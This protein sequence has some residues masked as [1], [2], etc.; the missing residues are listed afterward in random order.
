[1]VARFVVRA[2]QGQGIVATSRHREQRSPPGLPRRQEQ[3]FGIEAA[4]DL[5][6]RTVAPHHQFLV[7]HSIGIG[8]NGEEGQPRQHAAV[9]HS[10][11]R[12]Q[13]VVSRRNGQD[14]AETMLPIDPLIIFLQLRQ[15]VLQAAHGEVGIVF[16][17]L[18]A[19][20][21]HVGET[22]VALGGRSGGI[23][24]GQGLTGSGMYLVPLSVLVGVFHTSVHGVDARRH[25]GTAGYGHKQ[26][27]TRA[28]ISATQAVRCFGRK[29]QVQGIPHTIDRHV[30]GNPARNFR[31][32]L[33][34]RTELALR[35]SI[36]QIAA[37]GR[38]VLGRDARTEHVGQLVGIV[39][40]EAGVQQ[41]VVGHGHFEVA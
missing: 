31:G 39:T 25:A 37:P 32:S 12:G 38:E 1:M 17:V 21:R 5:H 34:E 15:S 3:V 35:E 14:L 23:T 36:L 26:Q 40:L 22:Q 7:L 28:G 33:A 16:W 8:R 29:P 4:D 11:A 19:V 27:S 24:L 10:C 41:V 9:C 2:Q 30:L 20:A 6:A 18:H 13:Q